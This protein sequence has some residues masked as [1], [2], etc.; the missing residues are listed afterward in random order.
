MKRFLMILGIVVLTMNLTAVHAAYTIY[1]DSATFNAAAGSPLLT[2]DLETYSVS[3]DLD[4]VEL[5]PGLN[6]TS[7]AAIVEAWDSAGNIVLFA[8]DDVTRPTGSMYY[9]I[10]LSNIYKAVSF[11]IISWD[12][13]A[14][15]PADMDIF[16]A[17]GTSATESLSQTGP[18]ES[19]PVFFGIISDVQIT[20]IRWN[21]APEVGGGGNEETALDD[22]TV[23]QVCYPDLPAP[24]LVTAGME[25]YIGSDSNPY[26]RYL[27]NVANWAQF[28]DELFE[29]SPDL[30]P[31]GLNTNS[32]RTWVSIFAADG[33]YI[34][35][36]CG[37]SNANGLNSIWF[38]KPQGELPPCVYITLEDRRCG[39]TYTSN[40]VCFDFYVNVDIKPGSC[41]NPFNSKSKGSVPVGI[42]GTPGFDV[43]LIDPNSISLTT[44]S[45]EVV[46]AL[47]KYGI[48][49]SV[50]PYDADAADCQDCFDADD[51]ANF[52]CDLWDALTNPTEPPVPGTDGILDSYCG[53]G[54]PDLIVKFDTQELAAAIGRVPRDTCVVLEL[55]AMTYSGVTIFGSDSVL[56]RRK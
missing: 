26:T 31:C 50:E 42:L 3:D 1:S 21:E 46:W 24:E 36:F 23:G 54:Y 29:A 44:P 35:G 12:P 52:N 4:G 25:N 18:T 47:G 51:P 40:V 53:D 48:E 37:I 34:Y 19:T 38:A 6:V 11:N 7:N 20:K 32:S 28:P 17:D 8:H 55:N 15:G 41:P 39:T 22:F 2:Q 27:L 13:A 33:T 45:G 5:L 56:T 49:D 14:P 9:D 10:N 16:F 43:T 30:D